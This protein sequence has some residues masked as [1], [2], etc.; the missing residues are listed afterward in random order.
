MK[1]IQSKKIRKKRSFLK[2]FEE[3]P[4]E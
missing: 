3:D 1:K 4:E 2:I